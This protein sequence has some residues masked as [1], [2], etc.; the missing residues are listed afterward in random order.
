MPNRIKARINSFI[1]DELPELIMPHI[2]L[3]SQSRAIVEG[4]KGIL[5]YTSDTVRLNCKNVIVSF[6]GENLSLCNLNDETITVTGK[7]SCINYI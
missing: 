5:Q 1:P 2:E 3:C 6:F 4:C 7:I